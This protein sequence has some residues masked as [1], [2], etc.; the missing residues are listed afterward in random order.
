VVNAILNKAT[1]AVAKMCK[2]LF[3]FFIKSV[4]FS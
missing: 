2:V 3:E 1:S 4:F